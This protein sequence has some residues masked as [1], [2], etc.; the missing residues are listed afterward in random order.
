MLTYNSNCR[1][2][3]HTVR[4]Y[5]RISESSTIIKALL[6][7]NLPP[8]FL[9][10]K[11]IQSLDDSSKKWLQNFFKSLNNSNIKVNNL[12]KINLFGDLNNNNNITT[13]NNNNNI[14]VIN[15]TSHTQ[16]FKKYNDQNFNNHIYDLRLNSGDN[17]L[18]SSICNSSISNSVI[19]DSININLSNANNQTKNLNKKVIIQNAKNL[20]INQ[21]NNDMKKS[22]NNE[23]GLNNKFENHYNTSF[24]NCSSNKPN[25]TNLKKNVT[26][27]INGNNNVININNMYLTNKYLD[28]NINLKNTNNSKNINPNNLG[29]N[30]F[31]SNK[32]YYS[33]FP[34]VKN[35]NKNINN[36]KGHN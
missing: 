13:N 15:S 10:I 29:F 3:K 31:D 8:Q 32:V 23:Y 27:L 25:L 28:D 20:K 21:N 12:V 18:N 7:E 24:D 1:L 14:N 4:C 22:V 2:I 33:N 17:S 16:N 35:L 6:L 11:F 9:D 34:E 26:N 5:S 36:S 30:N 19:N